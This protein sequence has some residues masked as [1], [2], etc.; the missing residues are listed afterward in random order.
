MS[1]LGDIQSSE[2]ALIEANVSAVK[3]LISRRK[4]KVMTPD[5]P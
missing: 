5:H 2:V 1:K 4:I 3:G